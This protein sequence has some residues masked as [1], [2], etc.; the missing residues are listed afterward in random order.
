[1]TERKSRVAALP[2]GPA[3]LSGDPFAGERFIHVVGK[4]K[5]S[6]PGD[7]PP[8]ATREAMTSLLQYAT[9]APKGVFVYR[10]HEEANRDRDKWTV[11]AMLAIER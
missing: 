2:G 5:Q 6:E 7:L 10:S 3:G 11:E 4:R 1:M 9:R 8:A